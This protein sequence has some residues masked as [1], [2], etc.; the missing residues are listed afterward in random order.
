MASMFSQPFSE[1]LAAQPCV[2]GEVEVD[3]VVIGSGYGGSVAALRLAEEGRKVLVLER[4]AE[5]RP[6]DFPNHVGQLPKYLRAHG[7]DGTVGHVGGVMDFRIGEG[8]ASLVANGLGGGSLIN[9]GVMMQPDDDVFAQKPWPTEIRN[10]L[11]ERREAP[12]GIG[13]GLQAAFARAGEMLEGQVFC[14]DPVPLNEDG[15]PVLPKLPQPLTFALDQDNHC[16]VSHLAKAQTLKRM[17]AA[18]REHLTELDPASPD[19]HLDFRTRP[20]RLTVNL[21]E[22]TRCG[23]CFT[24]CN[25]GTAKRTL[26]NTYLKSARERGATLLTS[27]L[28]YQLTPVG[29]GRR[30]LLRV[31]P[32]ERER[33]ALRRVDAVEREGCTLRAKL[34]VVAAGTYGSTEL[35]MRSQRLATEFSLSPA[36]GTRLSGNGDSLSVLADLPKPVDGVGLGADK[37]PARPVGPTITTVLDLRQ[38]PQIDQRVVIQEG[39]VPGTLLPIYRELLAAAW[40]LHHLGTWGRRPRANAGLEPLA[41]TDKMA[42]HT[43]LLLAM[44]HDGSRGRLVWMPEMDGV[45]PYWRNPQN[46]PT[47]QRQQQLFDAA[48]AKTGGVHLHLPSWRT[49]RPELA[50]GADG[51]LP[52]ATMM[53][54][55]PLGGCPMADDFEAGVVDHGGRLWRG[56][57]ELWN[58]IYVLDG[59]IMPTSL[60]CNPLWTITALAER[61]MALRRLQH[62]A[63]AGPFRPIP[64]PVRLPKAVSRQRGPAVDLQLVERLEKRKLRLRGGLRRALAGQLLPQHDRQVEA[65]LELRMRAQDWVQVWQQP[66]HRIDGISGTLRLL[67]PPGAGQYDVDEDVAAAAP[68]QRSTEAPRLVYTVTRGHIDL[69]RPEWR[70]VRPLLRV[71]RMLRVGIT[72]FVLRGRRD[73]RESKRPGSHRV[74]MGSIFKLAWM[75]T[76]VRHVRYDLELTPKN[77]DACE[78]GP[79][80]LWLTGTKKVT[81]AASWAEIVVHAWKSLVSPR[82]PAKARRPGDLRASLLDQLTEPA[83]RLDSVRWRRFLPWGLGSDARAQFDF[84]L[85]Q[86]LQRTPMNLHGGSDSTTAMLAALGYPAFVVR[87]LLQARVLE[88]RLPSYSDDPLPD[89]ASK[90]DV[91]LRIKPPGHRDW[92]QPQEFCLEVPVGLSSSDEGTERPARSTLRLRLWRYRRTDA[93]GNFRPPDCDPGTWCGHPVRRAK[94]VLLMHA[95]DMS[96]HS[97]TF[98]TTSKNFAEH[99]YENGWEVWVLDSRMSPRT[100]AALE[101]CTVDQLG[102]IDAPRAVNFILKTLQGELGAQGPKLQIYGFGQ[103]MGAAALLIGLLGGRLSHGIPADPAHAVGKAQPPLMPKLAGLVTSQTHPFIIGS[104]AAQS[105]TWIPSLLRDFAGRTMVTLSVRGP[106]T[107]VIESLAD[108]LFAGLPVPPGERCHHEGALDRFDDDCATCRR[109]RFLLGGMFLHRNLNLATHQELPKLFG[110]GSIRLF[111][112]GAK[113]FRHERLCSEDGFNVYATEEAIGRHLALPLRFVHGDRNDLFSRESATRSAAEYRR[114]HPGWADRYGLPNWRGSGR[115]QVCDVIEDY[116]HL[117]VLIGEKAMGEPGAGARSVYGRLSALLE[118][119]WSVRDA[120]PVP[121]TVQQPLIVARFPRSGPFLGPVVERNGRR[122]VGISF[123]VDETNAE[124]AEGAAA[125]VDGIPHPVALTINEME[126]SVP[127]RDWQFKPPRTGLVG[128]R[129]AQG[130]IDVSAETGTRDVKVRCVSYSW[131]QP[132]APGGASAL[133]GPFSPTKPALVQ[134]MKEAEDRARRLRRASSRPFPPTL[135]EQ[136]RFPRVRKTALATIARHVLRQPGAGDT[137]RVAI[138]CCRYGGFAFERQRADRAFQRLL[139][140]MQHRAAVPPAMLFMLGDQI[141]ADRTAGLFDELSPTERFFVRH[142]EAFT[143]QRARELLSRLP[144]AC[145]PDDHEFIDSYPLGRPLLRRPPGKTAAAH[146]AADDREKAARAVAMRAIAAYQLAQLPAEMARHGWCTLQRGRVRFFLLDTRSWRRRNANG[147]VQTFGH[148]AGQAFARWVQACAADPD[149]LACLVTSS[150]ILPGLHPG[151]DPANTGPADTM[152]A[153][154]R[155]RAWLLEQLGTQVPGRFVLLSGDYHVSFC[156]EVRMDGE[157]VGA[158]VIAPPFY[159]PLVYANAQPED[160][161][162]GENVPTPAGH[163]VSVHAIDGAGPRRGSGFGLLDFVPLAQ[164]WDVTLRAEVIDFE[165]E[166]RPAWRQW[167]PVLLG[168]GPPPPPAQALPGGEGEQEAEIALELDTGAAGAGGAAKP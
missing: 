73:Y 40:T 17:A 20:A 1:W 123:I 50:A 110:A 44:G 136:V 37:E 158:A 81:Y 3:A 30:W 152:Q 121:G 60:G 41:A 119:A 46:E 87:Y 96:G 61:A 147:E 146:K 139:A 160:L 65:D 98:K 161:W 35:L 129:V 6:G 157:R 100:L 7:L 93:H 79:Q 117:D 142:H 111:A 148:A 33:N 34:V 133:S 26:L 28:V 130:E 156:G 97:F 45:V 149:A 116:G 11:D 55:H 68:A 128:L 67:V 88:F 74:P 140:L 51:A 70:P 105:K 154:Q 12:G 13:L 9:A 95:F 107:S 83:V 125:L 53:S 36:L 92:L 134:A 82:D 159:A 89:V 64:E 25:N 16:G 15:T 66:R 114:I 29:R 120:Q 19:Q 106:V 135:S 127:A 39:A 143:T 49:V 14:D 78:R 145:L 162:L 18:M 115:P 164:G 85:Q 150:V 99:L 4:G 24:G 113:F 86:A 124:K 102:F 153:C 84:D 122:M 31:L 165:K 69:F 112:Q 43:Q 166:D 32:A 91:E 5:F 57:Y 47:F 62:P 94:S 131:T 10:G 58:N 138:G 22:C 27:A 76:E 2:N 109:I 101:P 42:H 59:S 103:C 48:E 80:T 108:R 132:N 104:R 141:Y 72:W 71:L 52:P 77:R 56:P 75:A 168:G 167:P 155:Q 54:V 126:V 23:D 137:V 8:M 90:E 63:V 118:Q 144:V 163:A 38:H 151:S 21:Q